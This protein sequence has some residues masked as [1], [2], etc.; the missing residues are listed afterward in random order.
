MSLAS[1][2]SRTP[3]FTNCP[4]PNYTTE[5]VPWLTIVSPV[6]VPTFDIC[7]S[8]YTTS[9]QH[10]RYA[11]LFGPAAPKPADTSTRCDFANIWTRIAW[12][13][14]LKKNEE[15]IG[16][17]GYVNL[18]EDREGLCPNNSTEDLETE[19]G[20]HNVKVEVN[21]VWYCLR[22][23]TSSTASSSSS[24]P[25]PLD[26][27]TLCSSCVAHLF[28]IFPSLSTLSNKTGG[29]F[30]PAA[31]GHARPGTC[32]LFLRDPYRDRMLKYIE[33]FVLLAEQTLLFQ[34]QDPR[35]S[36]PIAPLLLSLQRHTAIPLC[37]RS[38]TVTNQPCYTLSPHVPK[39]TVCR[40][41]H[42]T[43]LNPLFTQP[44]PP[45][46]L[47]QISDQPVMRKEGFSCQIY[48]ERLRGWFE[49]A[50]E[51]R[52]LEKLGERI[53]GRETERR[54]F[55]KRIEGLGE[56]LQ[57]EKEEA[58]RLYGT[59]GLAGAEEAVS[60]VRGTVGEIEEVLRGWREGWE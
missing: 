16:M 56:R 25:G 35:T 43:L 12:A 10:T 24:D 48:S 59:E 39:W 5:H 11:S 7:P 42:I 27:F 45:L 40:E 54:G 26:S 36:P 19:I 38:Q 46:V 33:C 28:T 52:D 31:N 49:E 3:T 29:I 1:V 22:S 9:I 55:W 23:S 4:Y 14:T 50:C 58:E 60:R 37:P 18:V 44:S 13:W 32:E 41:H 21:R 51:S 57:G 34:S 20:I 47:S 30:H 8:C 15:G 2:P 53:K 17:L 6:P